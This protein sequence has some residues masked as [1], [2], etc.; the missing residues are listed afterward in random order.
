MFNAFGY[1][2]TLPYSTGYFKQLRVSNYN[3]LRINS[4]STYSGLILWAF[5]LSALFI[6]DTRIVTTLGMVQLAQ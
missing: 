2:L 6:L 1:F 4:E 3:M 5:F